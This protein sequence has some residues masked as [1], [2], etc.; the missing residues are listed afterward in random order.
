MTPLFTLI[1]TAKGKEPGDLG[2]LLASTGFNKINVLAVRTW[3]T[4]HLGETEFAAH[5]VDGNPRKLAGVEIHDEEWL[6]Y[7]ADDGQ[8]HIFALNGDD[9]GCLEEAIANELYAVR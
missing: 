8:G 6:C 2:W 1:L 5:Q 4:R 7:A 3:R 9:L